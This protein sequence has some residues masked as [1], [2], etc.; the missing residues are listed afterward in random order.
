MEDLENFK[1]PTGKVQTQ[2]FFIKYNVS[3]A[4]ASFNPK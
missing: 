1:D 3:V 2:L 4:A